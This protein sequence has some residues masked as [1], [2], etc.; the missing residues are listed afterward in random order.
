[1]YRKVLTK[2]AID[3][4]KEDKVIDPAVPVSYQISSTYIS[5]QG[6]YH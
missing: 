5:V 1:M 6:T 4:H 2:Q 3:R